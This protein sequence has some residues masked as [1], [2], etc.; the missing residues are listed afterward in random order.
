MTTLKT[1]AKETMVQPTFMFK[2]ETTTTSGNRSVKLPRQTGEFECYNANVIY[3][4]IVFPLTSGRKMRDS[5]S[6]HFEIILEITN[7]K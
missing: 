5:G 1:A 2:S 4:F 3:L 6:N 7:E